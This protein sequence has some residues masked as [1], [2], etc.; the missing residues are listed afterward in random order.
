[1]LRRSDSIARRDCN[2]F[3]LFF[4]SLFIKVDLWIERN[5]EETVVARLKIV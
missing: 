5:E 4:K 3:G 1:M 2:F